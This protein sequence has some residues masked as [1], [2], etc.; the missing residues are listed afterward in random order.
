MAI[1]TSTER[2]GNV[3]RAVVWDGDDVDETSVL[4]IAERNTR[5]RALE[6]AL[7]AYHRGEFDR[8]PKVPWP[9]ARP[10]DR[11]KVC[12]N[13]Q[14]RDDSGNPVSG[15]IIEVIEAEVGPRTAGL[16]YVAETL[17]GQKWDI[18]AISLIGSVRKLTS[19]GL[20]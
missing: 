3:W 12:D 5:F 1:R 17:D 2:F 10:H 8:V 15:K 14:F 7:V 4:N 6:A 20:T 11:L 9:A 13:I 16:F 18:D 19:K